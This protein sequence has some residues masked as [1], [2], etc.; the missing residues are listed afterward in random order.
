MNSGTSSTVEADGKSSARRPLAEQAI[1]D[2]RQ[3]GRLAD[4]IRRSELEADRKPDSLVFPKLTCD[5]YLQV[6]QP[7]QAGRW[8]L[9]MLLRMWQTPPA[10]FNEFARRF[11][12]AAFRLDARG[13]AELIARLNEMIDDGRVHDRFIARCRALVSSSESYRT[14]PGGRTKEKTVS[15]K[16]PLQQQSPAPPALAAI[17]AAP[18]YPNGIQH[19]VDSNTGAQ[20]CEGLTAG[21][22]SPVA[23]VNLA[24]EMEATNASALERCIADIPLSSLTREELRPL[25]D[26]LLSFLERRE[27]LEEALRLFKDHPRLQNSSHIQ[28]SFLRIC[29]KLGRFDLIQ[30]FVTRNPAVTKTD[31]FNL[32]YELV[33]FYEA[34]FDLE[35]AREILSRIGDLFDTQQ[36]ILATLRNFYLRFGMFDDASRIDLRLADLRE[37]RRP[38]KYQEA[39]AESQA[40]VYSDLEHQRQLAALSD[41]T[42]GISHELGQPIT[43]IRYTIQLYRRQLESELKQDVVF[44]V[45]DTVLRETERMGGLVKRLAPVTSTRRVLENF[46]AVLRVQDRVKAER[47]RLSERGIQV[48]I[49]APK[50]IMMHAD[51]VRFDQLIS[52]L[53]LNSFDAI[54]DLP[55]EHA[56]WINIRLTSPGGRHLRMVFRDNGPGISPEHRRK[57]FEPFFSTKP[58]G[59]GEGLGLFIVWNL[60]KMQGGSI[61]LDSTYTR[62]ARFIVLLPTETKLTAKPIE[63]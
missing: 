59:R 31:K 53:L 14:V 13:K 35:R 58:P 25:V 63:P 57:I 2:M 22:L 1:W 21:I 40:E 62:G 5:M 46:D 3:R 17:N 36:P 43:N 10:L 33:Y 8:A 49:E 11:Q 24:R 60:L 29:R 44:S 54:S 51:P 55:R 41:M 12:R 16:M 56:G 18:Q 26:F 42:N 52:N 30:E 9:E 37:G 32:L 61:S 19:V 48:A 50:P 4:A 45:F 6:G 39:V 20:F 34:Q 28:A 38:L 15:V 23:L 7:E 27:R 47:A